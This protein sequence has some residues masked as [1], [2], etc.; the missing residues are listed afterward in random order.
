MAPPAR[1]NSSALSKKL[2]PGGAA[3]RKNGLVIVEALA[4]RWGVIPGPP[5]RKTVWAEI[6]PASTAPRNFP[7]R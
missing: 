3:S 6:S 1:S 7:S 2:R 5:P 4:D